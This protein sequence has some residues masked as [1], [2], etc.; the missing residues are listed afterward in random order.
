MY[1]L[2]YNASGRAA[3]CS[4][5]LSGQSWKGLGAVN[6]CLVSDDVVEHA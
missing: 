1:S 6:Y 4:S 5:S 2:I 3:V